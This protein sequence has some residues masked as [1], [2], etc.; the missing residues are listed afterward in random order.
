MKEELKGIL[1]KYIPIFYKAINLLT[2][3]KM[4]SY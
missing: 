3:Q 1:E 4:A 2:S